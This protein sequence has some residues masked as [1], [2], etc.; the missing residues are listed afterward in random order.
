MCL[1]CEHFRADK[2]T[3]QEAM[4]NLDEIA[5]SLEPEHIREVVMMIVLA[6]IEKTK[7][8]L[9]KYEEELDDFWNDSLLDDIDYMI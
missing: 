8:G 2:L 6:E 4:R 9:E 7:D 3:T 5:D 1:I